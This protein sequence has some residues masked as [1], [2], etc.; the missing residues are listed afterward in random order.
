MNPENHPSPLCEYLNEKGGG[1]GRCSA[2]DGVGRN[3]CLARAHA[4]HGISTRSETAFEF[5]SSR[6]NRE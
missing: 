6:M 4:T 5:E 2:F 3:S 1:K